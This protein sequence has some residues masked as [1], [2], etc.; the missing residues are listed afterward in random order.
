M[1]NELKRVVLVTF[2]ICLVSFLVLR[3][4][5]VELL[6]LSG[7][8]TAISIPFVLTLWWLFYFNFGWKW[9]VFNKILYKENINGTWFGTYESKAIGSNAST[10]RGEISLVIKQKFLYIDITSYTEKYKNYSYS[11]VLVYNEKGDRNKL[12]YVYSQEEISAKDHF[13]R[14]G[15][16]ELDLIINGNEVKLHGKFWTNSGT[17]G[18][19]ELKKVSPK[20]ITVFEEARKIAQEGERK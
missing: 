17:I 15:T 14:K 11:E 13:L 5:E 7:M 9:P 10:Y 19:L 6:S 16:S 4:V 18:Q 2:I 8:R 20:H 12:V 1:T 3:L